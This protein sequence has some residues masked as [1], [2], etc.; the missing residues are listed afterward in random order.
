MAKIAYGVS[1][2]DKWTAFEIERFLFFY[3]NTL[4]KDPHW[5]PTPEGQWGHSE[6]P[7]TGEGRFQHFKML[8][9][10]IH[11]KTFEWHDWSE[12]ATRAFCENKRTAITGCGGR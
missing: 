3:G 5:H 10:A 12:K 8:M 11:P 7:Y 2:P 4:A 9:Q 6:M 1:V